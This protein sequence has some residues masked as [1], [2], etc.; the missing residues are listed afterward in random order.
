MEELSSKLAAAEASLKDKEEEL[1][2]T[3]A[4]K[5]QAVA[6]EKSA[7]EDL[8]VKVRGQGHPIDSLALVVGIALEF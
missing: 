2:K 8:E 6:V 7:K 4:E 5:D 1:A 3:A